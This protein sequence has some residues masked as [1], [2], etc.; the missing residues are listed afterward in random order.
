MYRD[1]NVIG[2]ET[3]RLLTKLMQIICSRRESHFQIDQ[4]DNNEE[5]GYLP[6][7]I[8]KTICSKQWKSDDALKILSE[9]QDIFM[10][11]DQL[12]IALSRALRFNTQVLIFYNEL[13]IK[14]MIKEHHFNPVFSLL[15]NFL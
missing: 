9:F 1:E 4:W 3:V 11:K 5:N 2:A 6:D 10:T 15:D 14:H 8:L 7:Y 12:N 13:L